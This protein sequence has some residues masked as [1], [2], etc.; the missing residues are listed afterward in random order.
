MVS[1]TAREKREEA[2]REIEMR[3][4]VYGRKGHLTPTDEKRIA[5]MEEIAEDYRKIIED[6]RLL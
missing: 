1:Y 5:I 6:E 2:M 4:R 3:Q